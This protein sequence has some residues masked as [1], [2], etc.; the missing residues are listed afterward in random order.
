[1][2][3]IDR[4]SASAQSLGYMYQPRLALLKLLELP[5]STSIL[6]EKEDDIEFIEIDGKKSLASLK[7]KAKGDR[8]TDLSV[9][10][11]KSVR[12]WLKRYIS[13]GKLTSNLNFFLFTTATISETSFLQHFLIEHSN[14]SNRADIRLNGANSSLN[15]SKSPLIKSILTEFDNLSEAEKAD[16]LLR[17]VIL[18]NSSRI[19]DIPTL[20]K[21]QHMRSIRRECRDFVFQRLEG[22]WNDIIIDILSQKNPAP[23]SSYDVSDKLSAFAQEYT[24][25]NLPITYQGKEPST[26]IDIQKDPRRFVLQ[27]REIDIT[28]NRIRNAILDY[29]RAYNQRSAWA[30][31][32]LLVLG[33]IEK[34]EERLIDEWT[35]YRDITFENLDENSTEDCFLEAGKELYKWVDINSINIASLR[36]RERVTEPYVI[37]GGF[38]ILAN[39]QPTPKVYWHPHFFKRI[40][41]LP[42]ATE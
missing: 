25:D 14:N 28:A 38:H 27:L 11:W 8:L 24:T 36:I 23:I 19:E 42:E 16:F 32:K 2:I 3:P 39:S 37:R 40:N 30:R 5:E 10:F 34:Y 29:Y 12:I 9:D 13:E 31:E 15:Q 18:D 20:I 41:N 22:W 21:N 26:E 35:R 4:F 6:I 7:H 1:M 33:E 17:I